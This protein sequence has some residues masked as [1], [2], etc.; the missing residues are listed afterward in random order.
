MPPPGLVLSLAA[1]SGFQQPSTVSPG[2]LVPVSSLARHV[3]PALLSSQAVHGV[4][5]L[6]LAALCK[7]LTV[8]LPSLQLEGGLGPSLAM[9]ICSSGWVFAKSAW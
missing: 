8:L 9:G 5:L 3:P 1:F 4:S 6:W 2:S 7:A